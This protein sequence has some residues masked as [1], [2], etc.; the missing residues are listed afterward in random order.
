MHHRRY[1]HLFLTVSILLTACNSLKYVPADDALYTGAD[2]NLKGDSVTARDDK[3][4]GSNL[5]NLARPKPNTRFLGIPFKLWI[6]N[7]V[8]P[9]P[10]ENSFKGRLRDK[11]GEPPVLLSS[12]DLQ[13]NTKVLDSYLENKGF[14]K[15]AVTPDTVV[16]GRKAKAVYDVEAGP[17]YRISSVQLPQDSGALARAISDAS[18][19]T[20]LKTGDPFDLD[21]IK[22]ERTRIDAYLKEH[23]FYFFSPDFLIVK[24][25]STIG[26]NKVALYVDT[27]PDV[28]ASAREVY[29]INDVYIYANYSLNTASLDTNKA[30]AEFFRGY[31]IIDRDKMYRPYLFDHTM[32]FNPGDV[33][34]RTDHNVTLNRLINLN[35]FKFVKNRFEPV[36]WVD[37]PRL[38]AYYYLT[39]LP[40]K[41]LRAEITGLTKSNNAT[42]S[43]LTLSWNHRNTF[44]GGEQLRF[45][46]YTGTE[47]QAGG[48]LQGFNTYRIGAE[49]AMT[50]PRFLIPFLDVRNEGAY[51]PRTQLLLGYDILNKRRLY[52]L[53]SFRGQYGYTWRRGVERQNE[54]YPISITYVQPFNVTELFEKQRSTNILLARPTEPQFILGSSY[55]FNYNGSLK[56]TNPR[57][58][59]FFNGVADV[60]GNVAGLIAPGNIKAGDTAKLFNAAYAQ[61]IKAE[62]DFRYYRRIGL[63]STWAN[64][65]ILGWSN[66]YGNSD[67]LPFIKG[68]FSGGTNSVRA[69]R[70]RNLGPGTFKDTS[71]ILVDITGDYKLE[72][73]TEFRPHISG[74][75]YGALFVDA[76]NVW[77]KN[78]DPAKPGGKLTRNFL[79]ELAVGAGVGIRLDVVV[80]VIRLDVAVPIRKPW[81]QN[82]WVMRN[83]DLANPQWRKENIIYNLGIGYPF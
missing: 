5:K 64:R 51:A 66:P 77:V 45:S 15:A 46:G 83:I 21:V 38:N 58:W 63:Q 80:F 78:E 29:K 35:L 16:K 31:Y 56:P 54:L 67:R 44:R 27:K 57:Q 12:V 33:Y 73:N 60:S 20:L 10:A 13:Q 28:P 61:Y 3:V 59:F 6:Y 37:S 42:G 19:G 74:P 65:V 72:F 81:E 62:T 79:N 30:E 25:D 39:P 69:F 71:D 50:S 36:T 55:Q 82:P 17:L 34:N 75:L 32:Q 43:E 40:E 49:A 14:F 22:T 2:V 53:N 24:V 41:R 47:I 70:S 23:G 9:K 76:G 52:T 4:I 1:F 48:T 11:F 7:M 8:G 68:F 26:N 18:G